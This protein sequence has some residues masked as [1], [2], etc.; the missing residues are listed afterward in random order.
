M[1][2]LSLHWH[3]L[4][5]MLGCNAVESIIACAGALYR[6]VSR[7]SASTSVSVE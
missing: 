7:A 1:V 6:Y 2:W 3:A 5:R 4:E